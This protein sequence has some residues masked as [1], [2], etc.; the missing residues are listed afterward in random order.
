[1][2]NERPAPDAPLALITGAASGIGLATANLFRAH[3]WRIFGLDARPAPSSL[4]GADWIHCDLND[5]AALAG[6]LQTLNEQDW[7]AVVLCA[8]VAGVGDS[9]RVLN[10][11]FIAPRRMARAL[12]PRIRDG[13]AVVLVSS[14]AGMMWAAKREAL[15]PILDADDAEALRLALE[16]SPTAAKAYEVSKELLSFWGARQC[17]AEWA[18]GVRLNVVSPGAVETPLIADFAVSMGQNVLD[19]SQSV[20][21]RHARPG[22]IA[23]VVL[24]LCSPGASWINGAEIRVDGGLTA[25][26]TSGAIGF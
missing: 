1:L 18:R 14:G 8:G 12:T 16:L 4:E 20:T 3:G 22:E 11:N 10:I 2:V 17:L 6:A 15:A 19:F 25:A 24:F 9:E 5:G 7:S 13:G 26:F 23:E 21:G